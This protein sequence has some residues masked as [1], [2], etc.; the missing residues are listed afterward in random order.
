MAAAT[1]VLAAGDRIEE[2]GD[3]GE[4]AI[5]GKGRKMKPVKPN[6]LNLSKLLQ[7]ANVSPSVLPRMSSHLNVF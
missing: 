2:G 7:L 4:E 6:K 1:R 3:L 5:L